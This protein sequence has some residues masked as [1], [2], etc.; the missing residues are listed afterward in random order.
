VCSSAHYL[1]PTQLVRVPRHPHPEQVCDLPG[2]PHSACPEE[3]AHRFSRA[4]AADRRIGQPQ[5]PTPANTANSDLT[6]M[7]NTYGRVNTYE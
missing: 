3:R 2:H 5:Q 1:G 7:V 4:F 6:S